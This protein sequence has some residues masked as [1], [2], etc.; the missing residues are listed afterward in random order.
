M[1]GLSFDTLA[2]QTIVPQMKPLDKSGEFYLGPFGDFTI[3]RDRWALA[4]GE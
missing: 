2:N 1:G 4:G 3:G